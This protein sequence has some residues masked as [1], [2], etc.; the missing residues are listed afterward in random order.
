[1]TSNTWSRIKRRET[2]RF[3]SRRRNN[4]PYI[5]T[6]KVCHHGQFID[7][8]NIYCAECV[9]EKFH[10]FCCT[11]RTDRNDRIYYCFIECL[12]QLYAASSDACD[13]FWRIMQTI[14]RIPWIDTLWRI[15][16]KEIFPNFQTA[17]LEPRQD[18]LISS[19]GKASAF[20]NNKLTRMKGCSNSVNNFENSS[21][22][23]L[24]CLI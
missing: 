10:K 22:I 18:V 9:L 3:C 14:M 13:D 2:I 7:Q 11:S 17:L 21:N 8:A 20:Q 12:R 4:F 1:M 16:E 19:T 5:H 23:W 6:E 15:S 24:F